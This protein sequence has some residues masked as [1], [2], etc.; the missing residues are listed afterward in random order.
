MESGNR[1]E[2]LVLDSKRPTDPAYGPEVKGDGKE[3]CERLMNDCWH[4]SPKTRPTASDIEERM[5]GSCNTVAMTRGN[6]K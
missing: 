5:R 3:D 6:G 2:K 4:L 1:V